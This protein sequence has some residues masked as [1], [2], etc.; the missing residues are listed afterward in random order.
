MDETS[1]TVLSFKVET[2]DAGKRLDAFLS[3]QIEGWSRSRLQRLIEGGDVL[4]ND[5][6]TKASY[7]LREADEVEAEL[8]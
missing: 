8:T 2:A 6:E 5:R 3:E 4:V 7:R 1:S